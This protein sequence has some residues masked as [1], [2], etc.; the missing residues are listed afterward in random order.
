MK[1][2]EL[3][4]FLILDGSR[5]RCL[6]LRAS[7]PALFFFTHE[8]YIYVSSSSSNKQTSLMS[9]LAERTLMLNIKYSVKVRA[10]FDVQVEATLGGG[11]ENDSHGLHGRL[12][13]QPF[14][15]PEGSSIEQVKLDTRRKKLRK[16]PKSD[17]RL[18]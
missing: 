15:N 3:G 2:G 13:P 17:N 11:R 1:T 12:I 10:A 4:D 18:T 16:W 5:S 9:S 6:F 14:S 8:R 7:N